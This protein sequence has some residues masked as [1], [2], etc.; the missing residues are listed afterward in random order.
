MWFLHPRDIDVIKSIIW[1]NIKSNPR[2]NQGGDFRSSLP[3]YGLSSN[4]RSNRE[5]VRGQRIV[6][7]SGGLKAEGKIGFAF[8]EVVLKPQSSNEK[9]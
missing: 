4:H 7:P 2:R 1:K 5:Y 9:L 6:P 3:M 8:S